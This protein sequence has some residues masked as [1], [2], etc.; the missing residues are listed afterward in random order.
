MSDLSARVAV[1]VTPGLS[2][3]GLVVPLSAESALSQPTSAAQQSLLG[4]N[5]RR[6]YHLIRA[7]G[8]RRLLH[9]PGADRRR[10]H[11][12]QGSTGGHRW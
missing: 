1:F 10:Q 9:L 2:L 8:G 5:Q 12:R 4:V 6:P 11:P 3:S 7:A